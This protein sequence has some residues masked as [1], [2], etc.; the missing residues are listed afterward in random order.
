MEDHPADEEAQ[1][2][3]SKDVARASREPHVH[4][5]PARSTDFTLCGF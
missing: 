4:P 2:P 3:F 1:R 5:P